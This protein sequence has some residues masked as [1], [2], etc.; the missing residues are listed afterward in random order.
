MY[1]VYKIEIKLFAYNVIFCKVYIAC[2]MQRETV[3][4]TILGAIL[5]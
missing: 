3:S 2:Y 4:D 1:N 5:E